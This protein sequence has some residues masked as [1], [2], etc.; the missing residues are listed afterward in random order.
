MQGCNYPQPERLRGSIE[1][2]RFYGRRRGISSDGDQP[3]YRLSVRIYTDDGVSDEREYMVGIRNLGFELNE[4][5]DGDAL[6][7]TIVVNDRRIYAKSVNLAPWDQLYCNVTP[8][9][10]ERNVKLLREANINLVRING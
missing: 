8:E 4:G 7:Y 10:Y 5:S 6:P 1:G 9:L 2:A 3:L